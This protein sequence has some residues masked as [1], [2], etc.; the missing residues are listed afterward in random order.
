MR[1]HFIVIKYA[2]LND[3]LFENTHRVV[4]LKGKAKKC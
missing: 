3:I 4:K 2:T 1:F